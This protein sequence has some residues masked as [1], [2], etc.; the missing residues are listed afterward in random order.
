MDKREKLS[1]MSE[2]EMIEFILGDIYFPDLKIIELYNNE[3]TDAG[4]KILAENGH[5]FPNLQEF[6]L[7][8]N[9]ITDEGL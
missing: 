6:W 3:I 1:N 4:L 2:K 7:P 8:R 9:K 5:K